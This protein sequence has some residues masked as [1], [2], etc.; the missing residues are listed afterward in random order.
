MA[1]D[2]TD[3]YIG[4]DI[5]TCNSCGYL[6]R[7]AEGAAPEVVVSEFG[8]HLVPS[9]VALS[10]RNTTLIGTAALQQQP[11]NPQN[12]FVEFKRVIGRAC[13]QRALWEGD[14]RWVYRLADPDP[15]RG[16]DDDRPRFQATVDLHV[17]RLTAVDLY[18]Q[19]LQHMLDLCVRQL[20]PDHRLAGVVVTVPAHFDARQRRDTLEALKASRPL[21][22]GDVRCSVCTEPTAAAVAYAERRSERGGRGGAAVPAAGATGA[23]GAAGDGAARTEFTP[24][25]VGPDR[26]LL[27]F[28]LGAGTLDV[29]LL[30]L[31]G[32]DDTHEYTVLA[33]E[34][35]GDVGGCTFDTAVLKRAEA[36]YAD[37]VGREL[38]H[39]KQRFLSVRHAC[40]QA[41]RVL[42]LHDETTIAFG[43]A[44]IEPLAVTRA[45]FE[46][47]IRP[48]VRQCTQAV[49]AV[50][51]T[52][53]LQPADVGHVI[54]VGG[55]SRV[56][57]IKNTVGRMFTASQVHSGIN[58]DECVAMGAAYLAFG[59]GPAPPP[60]VPV[61]PA[62]PD[63]PAALTADPAASSAPA[64]PGLGS[65]PAAPAG[66]GRAPSL[67]PVPRGV[68]GRHPRRQ[69]ARL[70][71]KEMLTASLGVRVGRNTMFVALARGTQLPAVWRSDEFY[72]HNSTQSFV[73][74]HLHQGEAPLTDANV[75][76][77][78]FRMPTQKGHCAQITIQLSV[79]DNGLV[80]VSATDEDG[81]SVAGQLKLK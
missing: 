29:S 49:W 14:S 32:D 50:L 70:H 78:H 81:H 21:T 58:V 46:D 62:V 11:A 72:P 71:V 57:V 10:H 20:G 47:W 61:A 31:A 30:Q 42:S 63:A 24:A 8:S 76:L 51:Q 17:L 69:S 6:L 28:D 48:S 33:T 3:V 73:N 53:E 79:S 65:S 23:A 39:N 74:I 16:E 55:S 19:L 80:A 15:K 34:G 36:V 67:I 2:R 59:L 7:D 25:A 37:R 40:E 43:D 38:Q 35:M 56:P 4:L 45:E 52:A 41:K 75:S 44:D 5:G 26:R 9:V 1:A 22:M 66:R 77:G 12:T 54:L 68:V 18:T 13:T 27:V 64:R 60:A